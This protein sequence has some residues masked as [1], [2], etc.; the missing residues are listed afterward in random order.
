MSRCS[1]QYQPLL[2]PPPDFIAPFP[3]LYG[4]ADPYPGKIAELVDEGTF[5]GNSIATLAIYPLQYTP[6]SGEISC[7][8]SVS[9]QLQYEPDSHKTESQVP[10]LDGS[11]QRVLE[12]LIDNPSFID[13]SAGVMAPAGTTATQ[14]SIPI[15]SKYVV[16]TSQTLAPAFNRFVEWKRRKGV[17]IEV[18]TIEDIYA[19]HTGDLVSGIYDNA[20]KLR[21]FLKEAYNNGR[22]IEYALLA[23][24]H[25]IVP[26]RYGWASN[27]TTLESHIIPTDLYFADFDG[28]WDSN[29]NGLYGE[30]A[31]SV[32]FYPEIYV[33]RLL[34]QSAQE[35]E[36]WTDKLIQ[37]E[38]FPG[39]GDFGYL[40][41]A[42]LTQA[43]HL[44]QYGEAN[45][46]GARLTWCDVIEI[47]EEEG[48]Y[49]TPDTPN[50]PKGKDVIDEFNTHYGFASFFVHGGP[51]CVAVAT[52]GNNGCFDPPAKRKVTSMDSYLTWC[53]IPEE[54]NGI[55]NMTNSTHP[56]VFYSISCETMPF[57][58]YKINTGER[59]M[60]EVY[61]AI[62]QGGGPTYLGNTRYG[63]VSFSKLLFEKFINVI[64]SG[65]SY[66]IGKAEAISKQ[67]YNDRYL[68]FS[69]NL[70][71]CPE[72]ELWTAAPQ[73]KYMDIN[74]T[75]KS[76]KVVDENDA[77]L[78]DVGVVFDDGNQRHVAI[79]NQNGVAACPF[80]ISPLTQVSATKHNYLPSYT[81]ILTENETWASEQQIRGNVVVPEGLT[82]T[83]SVNT[84]LPKYTSLIVKES[85]SLILDEGVALS[86]ADESA[87]LIL[88][89]NSTFIAKSNSSFS[90]PDC[91][92]LLVAAGGQLVVEEGATLKISPNAIINVHNGQAAFSIHPNAV[93][94]TGFVHPNNVVPPTYQIA[95][96][97]HVWE[98]AAY[99]MYRNLVVETGAKLT[100]LNPS[101]SFSPD[102][103]VRVGVGAE[104]NIEGGA[105][106]LQ[107]LTQPFTFSITVSSGEERYSPELT[108][109]VKVNG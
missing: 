75:G 40:T 35:V 50:F 10:L 52:Q 20:G 56:T 14:A 5:R 2:P 69:H 57:D 81:Y 103:G 25:N 60:G 21:Q 9:I 68:R 89:G 49:D 41:K 48:G 26:I 27:N 106:L 62:S 44:Q 79:T 8:R 94:P 80:E 83:I 93:I 59:N 82:L 88:S 15:G 45:Y 104:L 43:D 105:L 39:N 29:G 12:Y 17:S 55:D 46:I 77:L 78:S 74:Y 22:G 102:K 4:S 63:W 101:L 24:R 34:V 23:G 71:G 38:S 1:T 58:E 98:N 31:D 32:D 91:S 65:L 96:G 99:R 51:R 76:V 86:L 18:V 95:S 97:T 6:A 92:E 87:S 42:F 53:E 3:S 67:V 33:G 109:I 54:G 16:V 36:N 73:R 7:Y 70:L 19:T 107:Y 66:E 72:T 90:M 64:T 100:L 37:Y 30:P 11:T 108:V 84:G 85:G 61:T 13:G 47:F 28:N